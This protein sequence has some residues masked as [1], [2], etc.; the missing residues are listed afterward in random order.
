[1][2]EVRQR[3]EKVVAR[4]K[5]ADHCVGQHEVVKWSNGQSIATPGVEIVANKHSRLHGSVALREHIGIEK[6]I[7][8]VLD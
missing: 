1:M 8:M 7:R 2:T 6:W 3:R 5:V 4:D